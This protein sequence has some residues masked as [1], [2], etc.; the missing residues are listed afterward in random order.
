MCGIAGILTSRDDL[1]LEPILSGMCAALGHRGPDDRG[2]EQIALG[3]G[4]RLGLAQTRLAILDV[5]A[6]GHQPMSAP[7]SQSWIVY[8][9]EIYNHLELRSRISARFRSQSDTETLLRA[10]VSSGEQVLA[11]LRGMFAF[12]LYDGTRRQLWLVRDRL[13]IKPLYVCRIDRQTWVFAS[14][15]RAILA[16]GLV[17]RRLNRPALAA[18]LAL[19]AVPAPWTLV[20]GIQ[21]LLPGESWCFDLNRP[22]RELMPDRRRYWRP[23]RAESTMAEPKWSAAVEEVRHHLLEAAR[24]HMLSDV[25]MAA[26]LSGGVDST[27]V[28]AALK[29]QNVNVRTFSVGFRERS[30]NESQHARAVARHLGTDHAELILEPRDVL[31]DFSRA[32]EAYDQ[33]SI[34]GLNTYF[35]SQVV[36]RAGA[37]VALSG[38]GGDELFAGYPYF[39]HLQHLERPG[40]RGCAL[41]LYQALRWL[42]PEQIRTVKLGRLLAARKDRLAAWLACREVLLPARRRELLGHSPSS[43]LPIIPA[44]VQWDLD[45]QTADLDC[46]NA[47][48]V[49]EMSLYMSNM[50]LRDTDQMSMAHALEVRVPLL[51]HRLVEAVVALP[52][53]LKTATSASA[54]IK[55]LLVEAVAPEVPPELLNRPK[56]GFVLP[57]ECWLRREL[58]QP[59]AEC[60]HD[61]GAIAAAGLELPAVESIWQQFL[62][63]RPGVRASD[64]L[65][66]VNILQWVRRH[67]ID[68]TTDERT[69]LDDPE[70]ASVESF[71]RSIA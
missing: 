71:A 67:R 9:G 46:V 35:I 2:L 30:F 51:D 48:S 32:L 57:W 17:E 56:Q 16:T 24:L 62:T 38:L 10:W 41:A 60:L 63:G 42:C 31:R 70:G 14:E 26:F 36:R 15:V 8:K 39:R 65:G 68:G 6:A 11:S 40:A 61:R 54:P 34:D 5:T 28:V 44:D 13:G 7:E 45:H 49:L 27:A 69:T 47:Q 43:D 4:L 50:L 25:P 64:V 19:G 22:S 3:R 29:A 37:T 18:C 23:R 58:R 53:R 12:G 59:I 55:R 52:G 21:S 20:S 1:D 33:P 66:L